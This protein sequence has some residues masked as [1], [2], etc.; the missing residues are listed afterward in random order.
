MFPSSS[1]FSFWCPDYSNIFSFDEMSYYGHRGFLFFFICFVVVILLWVIS[2]FYPLTHL[3]YLLCVLLYW[4]WSVLHFF[5]S[6]NSSI[7]DFMFEFLRI[8][9]FFYF[10]SI[11]LVEISYICLRFY[12]LVFLSFLVDHWVFPN[13]LNF[14][15]AKPKHSVRLS[16]VIG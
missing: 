6:L 9:I 5:H 15:L 1:L 11:S 10:I 3:F 2:K 16:S 13:I 7:S 8:Y 14:L 4:R 12:W